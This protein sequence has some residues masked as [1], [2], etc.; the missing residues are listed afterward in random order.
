MEM[1]LLDQRVLDKFFR[2]ALGLDLQPQDVLAELTTVLR[3]V[4]AVHDAADTLG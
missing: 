2:A 4:C 1:Y 3:R